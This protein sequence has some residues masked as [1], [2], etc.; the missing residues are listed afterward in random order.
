MHRLGFEPAG[1]AYACRGF[2]ALTIKPPVRIELLESL[3]FK[4]LWNIYKFGSINQTDPIYASMLLSPVGKKKKK[5]AGDS[6][7]K[8][9]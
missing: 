8:S 7:C 6:S 1:L 9:S 2:G 4:N 5:A 3:S